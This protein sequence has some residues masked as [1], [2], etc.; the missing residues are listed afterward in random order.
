MFRHDH[1]KK[2]KQKDGNEKFPGKCDV[3]PGITGEPR[4]DGE[5]FHS[6]VNGEPLRVL[7]LEQRDLFDAPNIILVLD[8]AQSRAFAGTWGGSSAPARI[9]STAFMATPA[10]SS[11]ATEIGTRSASRTM[12]P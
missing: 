10:S 12:S 7:V 11:R 5:Q 4:F 6:A 2:V 3:E 8:P 9:P 1:A